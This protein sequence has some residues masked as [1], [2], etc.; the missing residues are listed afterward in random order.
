MNVL[1]VNQVLLKDIDEGFHWTLVLGSMNPAQECL[2]TNPVIN[3]QVPGRCG[4]SLQLLILKFICRIYLLNISCE[5]L[6]DL[7][8]DES[9]LIQVKA[10]SRRD[11]RH[12]ITVTSK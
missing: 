12:Y 3:S 6:Q 1:N 4:C 2:I 10:S 7:F 8:V 11:T 5:I 9:A